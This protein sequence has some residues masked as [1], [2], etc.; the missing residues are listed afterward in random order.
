MSEIN[1]LFA[2]LFRCRA[3]NH[4][5]LKLIQIELILNLL[6]KFLFRENN[7]QLEN[8]NRRF[9]SKQLPKIKLLQIFLFEVSVKRHLRIFAAASNDQ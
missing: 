2:T 7:M 9:F 1:T 4:E 3:T 8:Y 5:K 6:T